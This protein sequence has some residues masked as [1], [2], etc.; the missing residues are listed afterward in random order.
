MA[1]SASR[2]PYYNRI[3]RKLTDALSP[4]SIVLRDE[5]AKHAGHRENPGTGETHFDLEITSAAFEGMKL[6]DRQRR[7]YAILADE[8]RERVHALSMKTRTPAEDSTTNVS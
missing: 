1:M 3:V 2:G 5:S 6:I 8:L 4:S 7:V